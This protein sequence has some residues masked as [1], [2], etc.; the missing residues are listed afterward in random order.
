MRSINIDEDTERVP[1]EFDEEL[2]KELIANASF[3]EFVDM[4][5]MLKNIIGTSFDVATWFTHHNGNRYAVIH[6]VFGEDFA[7]KI[8]KCSWRASVCAA[9]HKRQCIKDF[10][11]NNACDKNH[12]ICIMDC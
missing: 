2:K 9:Q 4:M 5:P 10:I 11:T 6:T 7:E 8:K 12:V 3:F 1:V